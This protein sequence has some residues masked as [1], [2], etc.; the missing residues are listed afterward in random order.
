MVNLFQRREGLVPHGLGDPHF[1]FRQVEII[2]VA[3][4]KVRLVARLAREPDEECAQGR[5]RRIDGGAAQG[6]AGADR[7]FGI[8]LALEGHRLRAV[9]LAEIFMPVRLFEPVQRLGH[10]IDRRFVAAAGF[11]Q[12]ME[13]F[14]LDPG[15]GGVVFCHGMSVLRFVTI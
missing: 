11:L 15:I 1:G 10:G 9:E 13:V 6:L 14:P 2:G 3:I 8:E 12:I 5:K 7:A 4:T